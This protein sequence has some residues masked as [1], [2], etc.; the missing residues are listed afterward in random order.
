M[1]L[2]I[3]AVTQTIIDEFETAKLPTLDYEI[4][5]KLGGVM[6]IEGL[7]NDERKGAWAES[8][9]FNLHPSDES[10]WG[11]YYC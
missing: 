7:S 5:D 8:T 9:A 10:P 3:P 2:T 11:T 6:R 4:A 1:A